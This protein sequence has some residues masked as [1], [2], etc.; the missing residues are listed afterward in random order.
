MVR[1]RI[2]LVFGL[3]LGFLPA[4]STAPQ[5][6]LQPEWE[7]SFDHVYDAALSASAACVAVTT[8]DSLMVIGRDGRELWRWDFRAG[9]SLLKA[10]DVAV[11]PACDWAAFTGDSGYKYVWIA[12][13]NGQRMA[14]PFKATPQ[15]IAIDHAG[16]R[17]AVG[18]GGNEN[19]LY[20]VDGSLLWS[21]SQGFVT[22]SIAFSADDG[23]VMETG[24]DGVVIS[25]AGEVRWSQRLGVGGMRASRDLGTFVTWAQAGHGGTGGL[26]SL[27]DEKGNMLWARQ[28][29]FEPEAAISPNG[30]RIVFR[31]RE[32]GQRE[33]T[34][35]PATSLA[36]FSRD[37]KVVR[38][39]SGNG[40]PVM[41]SANG[42]RVLLNRRSR[43]DVI[44]LEDRVVWSIPAS[45][46]YLTSVRASADLEH[47]VVQ[48]ENQLSWFTPR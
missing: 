44:D 30:D 17:F 3:L 26:V 41:F 22:R 6:P 8:S 20:A 32:D 35:E 47:I 23:W 1:S 7:R 28:S 29:A 31:L 36:L 33:D 42:E 48:E 24:W 37:G 9:N 10:R 46:E 12:R 40:I 4:F 21:R 14:I 19:R 45:R 16:R 18:S 13:R 34:R 2:T 43:V 27:L 25:I 11:S 39:F 38:K 5:G 15:G